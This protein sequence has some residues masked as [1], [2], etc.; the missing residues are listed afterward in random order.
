MKLK[1]NR[2]TLIGLSVLLVLLV[3]LGVVAARRFMRPKVPP[4]AALVRAE[5]KAV[6]RDS[7]ETEAFS[8]PV[9]VSPVDKPDRESRLAL[10]DP[11]HWNS[12]STPSPRPS[13][14]GRGEL[15]ARPS[16][17]ERKEGHET[18]ASSPPPGVI[19][20]DRATTFGP[21]RRP[22]RT[23]MRPSGQP[24]MSGRNCRRP[25]STTAIPRRHQ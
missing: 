16:A 25:Q 23:G 7:S 2:E 3:T 19:A 21:A 22:N 18:S 1:I 13:P 17:E 6:E 14:G 11:S 8:K 12:N 5:E 9:L 20:A 15:D 24:P 10:D 4:E